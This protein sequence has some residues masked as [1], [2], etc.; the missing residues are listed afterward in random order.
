MASHPLLLASSIHHKVSLMLQESYRLVEE[1]TGLLQL[2][3]Q[4]IFLKESLAHSL[5]EAVLSI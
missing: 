4:L 1:F 2:E 3:S 5:Q